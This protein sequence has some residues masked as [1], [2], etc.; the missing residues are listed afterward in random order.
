MNGSSPEFQSLEQHAVNMSGN[1]EFE[2]ENIAAETSLDTSELPNYDDLNN[3]LYEQS[4]TAQQEYKMAESLYDE[5]TKEDLSESGPNVYGDYDD[6]ESI[7]STLAPSAP[8][9]QESSEANATPVYSHIKKKN[10]AVPLKSIDLET[11]LESQDAA[12]QTT[13]STAQFPSNK[14]SSRH[15]APSRRPKLSRISENP[16]YERGMSVETPSF[17]DSTTGEEMYDRPP[18]HHNATISENVQSG[19]DREREQ[20]PQVPAPILDENLYNIPIKQSDIAEA[21]NEAAAHIYAPVYAIPTKNFQQPI[22][23]S[24]YNIIVKKELGMGQFGTVVLAATNGLSLKDMQ[25]SKT[26]DNQEISILVA[27][28]RLAAKPSLEE[29]QAFEK[30]VKLMSSLKQNN[31]VSLIGVCY[32]DPAF[33]MMEY[34][35][36][37]DLNQFLQRYSKIVSITTSSSNTEITTSTLVYIASQIASAMKYLASQNFVHRDLASRNCLVGASFTVKLADFGM[38]RNLYQSHYYRIQGN[39]VLPI[40]WMATESFFGIF[41]EKTDVWAFGITMWELFTLAKEDPYSHLTDAQVVD[42]AVK[43]VHRQLL[44]RPEACPKSVFKVIQQC[45]TVDPKERANFEAV[46]EMLQTF[47]YTPETAI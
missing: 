26:D 41:S 8:T 42:D 45:W 16:V 34:M 5:V 20:A 23:V 29:R 11:F 28:K 24:A 44:A 39:A 32:Q 17:L 25:L 13:S 7:P 30:E 14:K 27:V 37:G 22:E 10:P 19:L 47:W 33:I 43:G 12:S 3:P 6:T 15:S 35:E 31:I 4:A 40:R 2:L 21:E 1:H 36:E 38:S 18:T 9:Q 46:E